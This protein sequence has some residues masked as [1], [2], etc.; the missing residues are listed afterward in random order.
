MGRE[1][2]GD[3]MRLSTALGRSDPGTPRQQQYVDIGKLVSRLPLKEKMREFEPHYPHYSGGTSIR[4]PDTV[5]RGESARLETA[6]LVWGSRC[7]PCQLPQVDPL[8]RAIRKSPG[9]N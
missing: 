5:S 1:T 6:R 9:Q 3:V 4:N 7:A 8:G 2:S